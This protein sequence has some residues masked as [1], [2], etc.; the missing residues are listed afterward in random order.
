MNRTLISF[1]LL[2]FAHASIAQGT[3][4]NEA[5]QSGASSGAQQTGVAPA[6][7]S[8]AQPVAAPSAGAPAPGL[9]DAPA[10]APTPASQAGGVP[11]VGQAAA[12]VATGRKA[13]NWTFVG[14][15]SNGSV[16]VD[17]S[18][19]QATANGRQ[20]WFLSDMDKPLPNGLRSIK[21]H[22]EFDCPNRRERMVQG[23][24]YR[25]PMGEGSEGGAMK[26]P[27]PGFTQVAPDSSS[28]VL[29]NVACDYSL[30]GRKWVQFGGGES[31]FFFEPETVVLGDKGYRMWIM[32][33]H[34]TKPQPGQSSQMLFDVDCMRS[35]LQV[36]RA[37]AFS[38]EMG[39]GITEF[40][41]DKAT[42]WIDPA[43]RTGHAHMVSWMC[44]NFRPAAAPA[45]R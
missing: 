39:R 43:P 5:A 40:R 14:R 36:V 19:I 10:V 41:S 13:G 1:A 25:T 42:P 33:N 20:A 27:S 11:S 28:A 9:A 23:L 29:L 8:A 18:S 4:G 45:R 6:A 12:P 44:A 3:A 38:G 31:S 34:P 22:S 35:R 32:S 26:P 2:A 16:W 24:G 7:D 15:G 17:E 21:Q 30:P 37:A